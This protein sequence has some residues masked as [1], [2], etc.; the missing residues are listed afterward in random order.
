MCGHLFSRLCAK[1]LGL[2]V[3]SFPFALVIIV[4][5]VLIFFIFVFLSF[6]CCSLSSR[7]QISAYTYIRRLFDH[8]FCYS[9]IAACYSTFR[10]DLV[11]LSA[12]WW[13]LWCELYRVLLS[14]SADPIDPIWTGAFLSFLFVLGCH[15]PC[16][17]LASFLI[18]GGVLE[19]RMA[20]QP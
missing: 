13:I 1:I 3:S 9:V 2:A 8:S 14:G 15:F 5:P 18:Q 4:G 10:W 11:S 7:H 17:P 20:S 19:S 16:F 6:F 12:F